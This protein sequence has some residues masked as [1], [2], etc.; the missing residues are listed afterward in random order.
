M[1]SWSRPWV[2]AAA[3]LTLL[4]GRVCAQTARPAA[5]PAIDVIAQTPLPGSAIARDKTPA[6][7][8]TLSPPDFAGEKSWS[9]PEALLLRVP[10][11]TLNDVTGNPFQPDLRRAR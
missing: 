2:A 1:M 6:D 10:G 9:L 3:V 7:T 5:L 11:V 4:S 8:Q